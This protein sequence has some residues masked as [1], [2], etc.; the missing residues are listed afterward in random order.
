MDELKLVER[1]RSEVPL[2]IDVTG[3]ENR[4]RRGHGGPVRRRRPLLPSAVA[5]AACAGV[6]ATFLVAHQ[7]PGRAANVA[8]VL[9]RAADRAA[10]DPSPRA[11]QIVYQETVTR[12]RVGGMGRWYEVRTRTWLPAGGAGSGLIIEKNSIRPR[13]GEELPPDGETLVG[14]CPASP[15]IER[16]YL[17]ALPTDTGA[18]LDLLADQGEGDRGD[19]QWAAAT[20]LVDRP[21]PPRVRAA[22]YRAIAEIPGVRL[23]D[24]GVDAAG[25]H[26]VAV[27]RTQDGVR[28]ELVFDRAGHRFLGTRNVIADKGHP[29]GP[30]GTTTQSSAL[31]KTAIVDRAPLHGPDAT[32]SS[33]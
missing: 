32:P 23:R 25:R 18:L 27:T 13:P 14:P 10:G 28:D 29:F 19:R 24:D 17:G 16:P 21:A 33:C 7:E 30:P 12:R 4:W 1:L 9:D 31:L 20:D 15:P 11:G 8:A 6:V 2:D 22:L 26:G 3:A 5:A